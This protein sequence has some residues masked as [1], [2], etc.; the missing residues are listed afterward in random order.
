MT[1]AAVTVVAVTMQAVAVAAVVAAVAVGQP[2]A[3]M[4]NPNSWLLREKCL[5]KDSM[6]EIPC[7]TNMEFHVSNQSAVAT[8]AVVA[9]A[10]VAVRSV[11]VM[12][13]REAAAF[14]TKSQLLIE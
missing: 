2:A 5:S 9:V 8:T 11:A 6:R 12:A 7:T 14:L 10:A 3:C 4:T 13:A 1:L